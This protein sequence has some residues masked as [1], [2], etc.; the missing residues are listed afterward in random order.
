M[1][2]SYHI[3]SVE[4][5]VKYWNCGQIQLQFQYSTT[6][7]IFDENFTNP[8][9]VFGT[10]KLVCDI[11]TSKISKFEFFKSFVMISFCLIK[12]RANRSGITEPFLNPNLIFF[13]N[14]PQIVCCRIIKK[15]QNKNFE[16][17]N[18]N[19]LEVPMSRTSY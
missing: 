15:N 18:S 8:F 13:S 6:I 2:G 16:N 9:L 17:S 10:V 12:S 14:A 4:M 11:E 7:S 19:I 1:W 3:Q 5:G